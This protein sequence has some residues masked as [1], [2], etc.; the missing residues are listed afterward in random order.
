[1]HQQGLELLR[2][3]GFEL[4]NRK[5]CAKNHLIELAAKLDCRLERRWNVADILRAILAKSA[6]NLQSSPSSHAVAT[7]QFSAPSPGDIDTLHTVENVCI[8]HCHEVGGNFGH[9]TS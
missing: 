1:L 7:L 3:Q 6:E 4:G 5:T 8:A 9:A 2:S